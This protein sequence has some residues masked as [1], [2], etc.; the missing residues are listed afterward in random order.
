MSSKRRNNVLLEMAGLTESEHGKSRERINLPVAEDSNPHAGQFTLAEQGT[1]AV[2]GMVRNASADEDARTARWQAQEVVAYLFR[3]ALPID[4]AATL[5]AIDS[6]QVLRR[7]EA[8]T[9]LAISSNGQV[10][11][12]ALQFDHGA[13]VPNLSD[14]LRALPQGMDA[15]E[16]LSWWVTPNE[17]LAGGVSPREFLLQG[18]D[19]RAVLRY[20]MD[21]FQ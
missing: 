8:G 13:E 20:A 4:E 16:V 1:L 19:V 18:G 5:L 7:V 17:D 3:T 2:V 10:R 9:L 15:V 6:E 14:V 12:P 11:I 21:T